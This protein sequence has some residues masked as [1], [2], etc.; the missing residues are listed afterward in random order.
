MPLITLVDDLTEAFRAPAD[1]FA[2]IYHL[3]PEDGKEELYALLW[4]RGYDAVACGQD[5]DWNDNTT[6]DGV[7]VFSTLEEARAQALFL[8]ESHHPHLRADTQDADVDDP[9]LEDGLGHD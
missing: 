3:F 9:G 6:N 1:S 8:A 5:W 7:E 2:G 4:G